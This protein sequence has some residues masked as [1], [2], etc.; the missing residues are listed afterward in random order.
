L[1]KL[2]AQRDHGRKRDGVDL[3]LNTSLLI[4]W[5]QK[6]NM[7][8]RAEKKMLLL[9]QKFRRQ[10]NRKNPFDSLSDIEGYKKKGRIFNIY[11]SFMEWKDC[12]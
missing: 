5:Q 9:I 12:V 2:V 10:R 6:N 7:A 8:L 4:P 3:F 1:V 11:S